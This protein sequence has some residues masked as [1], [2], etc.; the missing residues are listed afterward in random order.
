MPTCAIVLW[1]GHGDKQADRASVA[2]GLVTRY[3]ALIELAVRQVTHTA[4]RDLSGEVAQRVCEALWHRLGSLSAPID[5]P[6]AYVYRC[7]IRHTLAVV[8]DRRPT[9]ELDPDRLSAST[10]SPEDNAR[11][12]EL[13]TEIVRALAVMADDRAGATHAHLIGCS[14]DE[15]MTMYDWPYHKARNLIAR[16]MAELRAQLR[17]RGFS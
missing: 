5:N 15:I 4:D 7:A 16:G 13:A 17:K 14:V 2:R 8:R 9:V 10:T 1:Q 12:D 3:G 6:A 11:A